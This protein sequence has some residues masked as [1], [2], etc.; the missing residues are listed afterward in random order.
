[1]RNCILILIITLISIPVFIAAQEVQPEEE[2]PA[3]QP[4]PA[5]PSVADDEIVEL[6]VSEIKITIEKPQ[7]LLFS[8]RI[9]PEFDEVNLEKSFL[10]EI[11][12]ESEKF[13][14]DFSKSK[15]PVERIEISKLIN[16]YR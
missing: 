2:A 4:A 9:K 6:G 5:A 10:N 11:T 7:V 1:M 8:N 13:V 16:K 12:G 3:E 15:Q 14:F